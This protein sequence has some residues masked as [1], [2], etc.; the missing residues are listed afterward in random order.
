[1]EEYKAYIEDYEVS[2]L[3]NVRRKKKTGEYTN[4]NGSVSNKGYKYFQL[5]RENIRQNH[6]IH[7]VVAF[8]FIGARPDNKVIDHIDRNKLNNCVSNLRYITQQENTRNTDRF[9]DEVKELDPAKRH[10]IVSKLYVI[11]N[12]EKVL[13]RKKQYYETHKGDLLEKQKE[14]RERN[15]EYIRESRKKYYKNQNEYMKEWRKQE[16]HCECGSVY[17]KDNHSK[18]L[19]TKFHQNYESKKII[20]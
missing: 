10:G 11:N 2:N 18:H 20:I 8:L 1:M 13:A 16:V 6:Y 5:C 4:L 19:K 14:Y 3:G 7:H 15:K 9:K 17:K 12:K